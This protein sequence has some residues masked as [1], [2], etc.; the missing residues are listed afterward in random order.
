MILP[1]NNY[2]FIDGQNLY[3]SIKK[4]GW[5]LDYRKFRIYLWEKYGVG[6]AYVFIGFIE[7]N[8][9]LYDDLAR[10]DFEPVF[11]P[12]TIGADGKIKGNID[13]DLVLRAVIE[14]KNYNKAIIVSSDGDFYS[15]VKY[16]NDKQKLGAVL[17]PDVKNCSWLLRKAA[18]DKIWFMD[19]LRRKL[20]YKSQ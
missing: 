11:R 3:L 10:W 19:E 2:A 6:K 12:V 4:L 13:A 9:S 16:L 14:F 17:S 7:S 5:K 20:E 1:R 8:Q 18:G 15:L